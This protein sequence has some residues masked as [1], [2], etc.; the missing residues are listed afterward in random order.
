MLSIR[1]SIIT[2]I[3]TFFIVMILDSLKMRSFSVSLLDALILSFFVSVASGLLVHLLVCQRVKKLTDSIKRGQIE[4]DAFDDEITELSK[5]LEENLG[6]F[7]KSLEKEKHLKSTL[8]LILYSFSHDLRTPLTL[9][10]NSI[11][12]MPVDRSLKKDALRYIDLIKDLTDQ[13]LRVGRIEGGL[14]IVR[15]ESVN[16]VEL[17]WDACE[18]TTKS[19]GRKISF[20]YTDEME[21]LVDPSKILEVTLNLL[22]NAAEY[23]RGPINVKISKTKNLAKVE[24]SSLGKKIPYDLNVKLFDLKRKSKGLGLGLFI[25]R[26]Y[27]EMHNGKIGYEWKDG[28]NTFYFTLP[29]T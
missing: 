1:V 4:R 19:Y 27:V 14:E 6:S 29:L 21:V 8:E 12:E 2:F 7:K 18:M 16:L 15:R 13:L 28:K 23:S 5:A 17:V 22:R 9:L 10:E 24:I 20:Q 3:L 25:A 11:K 26:R